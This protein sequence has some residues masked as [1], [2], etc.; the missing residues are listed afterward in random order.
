MKQKLFVGVI[1][2]LIGLVNAQAPQLGT[3]II[4]KQTEPDGSIQEFTF[5]G[6]ISGTIKDGEQIIYT[7]MDAA[8]YVSQETQPTG[9][10]LEYITCDQENVDISLLD[11]KVTIHLQEGQTIKCIFYNT[12]ILPDLGDAPDPTNHAGNTMSAYSGV[13]ANYPTVYDPATGLPQGP[14]HLKPR[15]DAW[16]GSWVSGEVDAD[17]LPDEDG[18]T[19]INP[20]SNTPDQDGS[21]DGLIQP[22]PTPHGTP[23]YFT[24][25]VTIQPGAP[26]IAR[27]VNVWFDWNRDGD[28]ADTLTVSTPNDAPEWAVQN[29]LISSGLP[30]GTYV[31]ATPLYMPYNPPGLSDK[32]L[33]MRIS[34][35]EQTAPSPQDGRGPANAYEYGETEDYL[36]ESEGEEPPPVPEYPSESIPFIAALMAIGITALRVRKK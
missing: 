29:Q 7:D 16:L 17:L 20:A 26:G 33:W 19:N 3:I 8:T 5:T 2:C 4:E 22:I 9:W 15:G 6:D 13:T 14:K 18:V 12:L 21:D 24:Y 35:A 28:W 34:I 30:P 32:E 27:Y 23:S 25:T 36:I 11:K 10:E 1:I 31:F